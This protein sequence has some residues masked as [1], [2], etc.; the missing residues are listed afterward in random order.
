MFCENCGKEL[1][2]DERFCSACGAPSPTDQSAEPAVNVPD[3]QQTEAAQDGS[4][5]AAVRRSAPVRWF[6]A[7]P[8]MEKGIV[9]SAVGSVLL[10]VVLCICMLGGRG[11]KETV[12]EFIDKTIVNPSG[13]TII[14]LVPNKV[15]EGTDTKDFAERLDNSFNSQRKQLNNALGSKWK[16]TYAII[17]DEQRDVEKLE[18]IKNTYEYY[19]GIKVTDA[20][21][22]QVRLNFKGNQSASARMSIP[23]VQVGNS[24]YID[25][26][27]M[28]GIRVA[29]NF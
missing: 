4:L 21:S 16:M 15:F 28:G 26:V 27:S 12:D 20:R 13:K 10:L 14:S 17:S 19:Y 6:K 5:L 22:V 3:V 11:Y 8:T 1:M 25:Y 9:A 23:V 7:L 24:W 2:E 29:L 18:D